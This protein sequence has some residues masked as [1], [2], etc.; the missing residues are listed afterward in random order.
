[1]KQ[2]ESGIQ[3]L[4]DNGTLKGHASRLEP[5]AK[6]NEL[7]S[8][9]L[10]PKAC[11]LFISNLKPRD[12]SQH[13]S[14]ILSLCLLCLVWAV[15]LFPALASSQTGHQTRETASAPKMGISLSIGSID[16]K[17][18]RAK[19]KLR[20]NVILTLTKLHLAD[21]VLQLEN[22]KLKFPKGWV[23]FPP[24][25]ITS[26][27][28][29]NVQNGSTTL[30][31]LQIY[32]GS[33]LVGHG[34][35]EKRGNTWTAHVTL[36][37][38]SL[39]ARFEHVL[40]G[41]SQIHFLG[42]DTHPVS[43][44]LIWN[45]EHAN[46]PL[47]VELDVTEQ[48]RYSGKGLGKEL[49]VPPLSLSIK[50]DPQE[51]DLSCDLT[52]H[53]QSHWGSWRFRDAGL[54]FQLVADDMGARLRNIRFE[55]RQAGLVPGVKNTAITLQAR[56][57]HWHARALSLN[58]TLLNLQGIG[59]IKI[60]G[61]W[62][63][64]ETNTLHI[65][66]SDLDLAGLQ[67]WGRALGTDMAA[68][69]GL[70]GALDLRAE[71]TDKGKYPEITLELGLQDGRVSSEDSQIMA[72]SLAGVFQGR[73]RLDQAPA[74]LFNMRTHHGQFLWG[75]RY[76]NLKDLP[77][78][79]QGRVTIHSSQDIEIATLRIDWSSILSAHL[80]SSL[81]L[82]HPSK[83]WSVE[84]QESHLNLNSLQTAVQGLVPSSLDIR[85]TLSWTG[86]LSQTQNSRN[87]RGR[88]QVNNLGLSLKSKRVVVSSMDIDLPC[89]AS[90]KPPDQVDSQD[91]SVAVPWGWLK[92]GQIRIMAD[93]VQMTPI[94]LRL[95]GEHLQIKNTM[96]FNFRGIRAALK[97][98][99][100]QIPW[101]KTWQARGYLELSDL[102]P[103]GLLPDWTEKDDNI[104]GTIHFMASPAAVTTQG[105]FRGTL[106]D[107]QVLIQNLT[108]QNPMEANRLFTM[109]IH[110]KHLDLEPM[111]QNLGIGR[112]TGRLNMAIDHLGIAYGQPV[113]FHLRAGS[114]QIAQT[115]RTISLQAVNSLSIIGT[116]Q[117][118][119]GL[120]IRLFAGFFKQFAYEQIGVSCVLAN[121]IFSLNGLIHDEGVE[122]IVKRKGIGINV[123][124]NNPNNM[125]AFSDMLDRLN[126][127][128]K[129]DFSDASQQ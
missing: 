26:Q 106:C 44:H 39:A 126:R 7:K 11:S 111:S 33:A 25:R 99:K 21:L 72:A 105:D 6:S 50:A 43:V 107:G 69:W 93:K 74:L 54:G 27:G 19:A 42:T 60:H 52:T 97:D 96:Q 62:G 66:A 38:Q 70:K 47:R 14:H 57:I 81:S 118:L 129:Q 75:T 9:S 23:D 79:A 56:Q 46:H 86:T 2:K 35:G 16:N 85:G 103:A 84:V 87:V 92:P 82:N 108:L 95:V 110:I 34:H 98:L 104:Q 45:P 28:H 29:W 89:V 67:T 4:A 53:G 120:G 58:D 76:T 20:A 30:N 55:C 36:H 13:M 5:R 8:Q 71:V 123:I 90:F 31:S 102:S 61:D 113:R 128:L 63:S 112:I 116:G 10:V 124:N 40:P 114:P 65:A 122:Y 101:T 83:E 80:S 22:L 127:V 3:R 49:L 17:F 68:K 121:D 51:Q 64:S 1:M 32:T 125:I 115:D 94:R 77:L 12:C 48:F 119:S 37:P 117:G 59:P 41:L 18:V 88:M 109:D 78:S 15:G 91:N 24:L 100:L 73:L